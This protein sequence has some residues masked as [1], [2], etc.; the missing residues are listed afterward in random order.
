MAKRSLIIFDWDGTLMDSAA[1]IV[2]C[3]QLAADE[4]QV[5]VPSDAAVRQIIGLGL[6]EALAEL[7]PQQEVAVHEQVRARYAQHF[8]AGTGGA[9]QLFA[10]VPELLDELLGRGHRLAVATGKSRLGLDR[11]LGLTGLAPA[12]HATRC[13]D[14]TASKPDP[15]M[16]HELLAE[17][18][19]M[20]AEAVM[21][22]DTTYDLEMAQ[23]ARMPRIGVSYG[24]HSV[25]D[26][27]RFTPKALVDDIEGLA[28][29]LASL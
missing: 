27:Q 20:P 22:G 7:F 8:I 10:G 4:C 24:V 9:S 12:F 25:A 23:R 1:Q 29:A 11:V 3:M 16:L 6:P 19:Y 17:L 15:R 18:G 21:V 2:R 28:A 14:E 5:A 26:L 13:A